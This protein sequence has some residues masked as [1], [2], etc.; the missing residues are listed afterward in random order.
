MR[1]VEGDNDKDTTSHCHVREEN[2]KYLDR[3]RARERES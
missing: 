1:G 3:I 2:S